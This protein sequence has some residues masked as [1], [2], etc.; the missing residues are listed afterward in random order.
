MARSDAQLIEAFH[1]GFLEVLRVRLKPENYVLKGG[2][3][4][5]YFFDSIRYSEDIDLDWI[6]GTD[7]FWTLEDKIPDVLK[8]VPLK[9]VLRSAGIEVVTSDVTDPEQT[10]VT[11]RWKV[12]ITTPGRDEPLRTKIEVSNRNVEDRYVLESVPNTVVGPYGLRPPTVQR[13]L[14]DPATRQKVIALADRSEVQTRD[15]FDLDML[16]RRQDLSAEA[17]DAIDSDTRIRA[18]E[19]ALELTYASFADRVIPFLDSGMHELYDEPAWQQMQE[20]VAQQVGDL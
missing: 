10:D 12:P 3:N 9:G 1:L 5:R 14:T 20:F 16:L 19:R 4:L 6:G 2:A 13:Y 8:S 18:A 17:L 7:R 11:R 15:V